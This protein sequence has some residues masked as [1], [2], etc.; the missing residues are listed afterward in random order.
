MN[1]DDNG[2]D[3]LEFLGLSRFFSFFSEFGI[4]I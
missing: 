4:N 2:I 3:G 1:E